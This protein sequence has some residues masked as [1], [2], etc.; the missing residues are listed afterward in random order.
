M[1]YRFYPFNTLG[2]YMIADVVAFY[3]GKLLLSKH[4][5]RATWETQGGHIEAGE[6]PLEAAKRELYEEAGALTFAIEPL[7]DYRPWVRYRRKAKWSRHVC[8]ILS[9]RI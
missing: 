2:S 9:R 7:C 1:E 8:L 3:Q 5:H 4:K 6:A